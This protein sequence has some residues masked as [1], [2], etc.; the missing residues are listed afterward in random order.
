[1]K[2]YLRSALIFLVMALLGCQL[3]AQAVEVTLI[4]NGDTYSLARNGNP[5]FIKGAGGQAYL[6]RLAAY[7]GNSIRT[8]G[9]DTNTIDI[10]DA[11]H[12]QGLTVCMGLWVGHQEHGFNYNDEQA[13]ANQLAGFKEMVELYKDHPAVLLW[14]IGNEVELNVSYSNLNLKVWEAINE[15][16]EMIHT[17]D[18][19]HP[20]L[21]V[22][23]G[24]SINKA[25]DIAALAPDLDLIGVNAYGSIGSVHE[26]VE[27]SNLDLPY[28]I[29]E[30]GPNGQW[31]VQKTAWGAPLEQTS[32]EKAAIYAERY[33]EAILA[34][35]DLCLG[36]YV[37]LWGDKVEQTPTWFGLFYEGYETPVVGIMQEKWSGTIRAN[38]APVIKEINMEN[39]S[40]NQSIIISKETG[41]KLTLAIDDENP[42]NLTYQY[43]FQPESGNN[44][45]LIDD[46]AYFLP[47][48]PGLIQDQEGASITFDAPENLNNYRLFVFIMDD[49]NQIATLNIPFKVDLAPLVSADPALQYPVQDAY[50]RNGEYSSDKLGSTDEGRLVTR[51]SANDDLQ[52][53]TILKFDISRTNKM[54]DAINVA[55]F[56]GNTPGV[57]V[58]LYATEAQ[59]SESGITWNNFT[60]DALIPLDTITI[61]SNEQYYEWDVTQFINLQLRYDVKQ[62]T[63]VLKNI[64]ESDRTTVWKSRETRVY[65]P[66]LNFEFNEQ[67]IV[68]SNADVQ[69]RSISLF[70]NPASQ[71]IRLISENTK[72][73]QEVNIVNSAGMRL[74]NISDAQLLAAEGKLYL[75][76]L[77][78]GLYILQIVL[79]NNV[80][81]NKK[82]VKK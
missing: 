39:K 65:P 80:I 36:S 25:N 82:F 29:T 23:A 49:H 47:Y 63:F 54:S 4:K 73:I 46:G 20:T 68:L 15:I 32:T 24:L 66:T 48:I 18:G 79:Q 2:T 74:V 61:G 58:V 11:A 12:A 59:W 35:P 16:S 56:G 19:K 10:L 21:T 6:D 14:A 43:I 81:V 77:D 50:I 72:R 34:K 37:F 52:R 22:T 55:L 57:Q 38:K 78:N 45:M 7:G 8:W 3:M 69:P 70:P 31:E 9:T 64:T 42:E 51:L 5:Y 30:W 71:Y 27:D 53:Q 13:V 40:P 26:N 75:D 17:V 44:Q 62:V 67:P 41:N 76:E 33:D 1:M 60:A 28:V